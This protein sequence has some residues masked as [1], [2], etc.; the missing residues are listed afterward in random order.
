MSGHSAMIRLSKVLQ[1]SVIKTLRFNLHYFGLGGVRLPVLVARNYVLA[2]LGGT[3]RIVSP[4]PGR[5]RLGYSSVG[6][7]DSHYDRGIWQS[8]GEVEFCGN[9]VFGSGS[10]VSVGPNGRLSIGDGFRN[11]AKGEFVCHERMRLGAHSLVS[12]DTLF[13]DTDFHQIDGKPVSA[14]VLVGDHV[15]VGCR[16][17]VLKGA[18]IPDGSVV[19]AGATVTKALEPESSLFGGVN[20]VLRTGIEWNE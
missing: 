12:W 5:V 2:E 10:K 1:T 7:F 9:A 11:T 18:E 16:C 20:K 19:A 4:G 3:V 17:M 6:I 15:W 8:S 14:P 13:M